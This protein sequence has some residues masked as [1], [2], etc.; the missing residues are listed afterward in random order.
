MQRYIE[1]LIDDLRQAAEQAPP[2]I[3]DDPEI[4]DEEALEMELEEAE[5]IVSGPFEKLSDILGIP[6]KMLP[7]PNR[8][9]DE[10]VRIL[11]PEIE[12]LLNAYNFYPDYP[13][14]HELVDNPN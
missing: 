1:Q 12:K 7:G 3:I 4:D 5:R 11:V 9:K 6:K 14:K 8:L 10:H 13:E 2:D